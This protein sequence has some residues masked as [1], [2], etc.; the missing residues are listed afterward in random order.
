[1]AI[2]AADRARPGRV[3]AGDVIGTLDGEGSR[4]RL[5]YLEIGVRD[6]DGRWCNPYDVLL[7][8]PDADELTVS[9]AVEGLA[10]DP[11]TGVRPA[12]PRPAR[13]AAP[14][15]PPPPA[16]TAEPEPEPGPEPE[17]D[18][19]EGALEPEPEPEEP[20]AQPE[21]APEPEPAPAQA[22]AEEADDDVL[23]LLV[24]PPDPRHG[25]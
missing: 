2:P 23:S 21:P 24:A 10:V 9:A 5:P 25:S 12:S 3:Q 8:L 4:L 15:T 14:A 17:P 20:E 6:A 7:G 19:P 13:P 18:E 16:A 11:D 22:E 1:V